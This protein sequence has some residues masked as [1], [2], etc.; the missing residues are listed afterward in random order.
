M[1]HMNAYSTYEHK[2]VLSVF[3]M[4]NADTVSIFIVKTV[5]VKHSWRV[6]NSHSGKQFALC[7]FVLTACAIHTTESGNI[8][9]IWNV[10]TKK[11]IKNAN[12]FKGI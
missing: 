6:F 2:H 4:K 12:D 10:F 8:H 9:I 11:D 1:A 5:L 7:W 3:L